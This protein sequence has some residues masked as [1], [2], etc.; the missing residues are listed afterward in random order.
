[1]KKWKNQAEYMNGIKT[2]CEKNEQGSPP[3][4]IFRGEVF[5]EPE[6]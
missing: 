4:H 2:K 1:M 5:H 3:W 6:K